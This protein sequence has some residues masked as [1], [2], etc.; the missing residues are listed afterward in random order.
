METSITLVCELHRS[1]QFGDGSVLAGIASLEKAENAECYISE[2]YDCTTEGV[3]AEA[4]LRE[5]REDV[6][7][8][9]IAGGPH[10]VAH[11]LP[12]ARRIVVLLRGD[13]P[14]TTGAVLDR[15][16]L[17]RAFVRASR[18]AAPTSSPAAHE[19]VVYER[20]VN[21]TPKFESERAYLDLLREL[22]VAPL[23][24]DRTGTGTHSV[25][26][27]QL[28]FDLSNG[29]LPLLT[30]RF[31]S[32]R[33]VVTELLWF[34][35]GS[36]DSKELEARGFG[37]WKGNSSREFLDARGLHHLREGDIGAAYGFQWRHFGAQ[38]KGCDASHGGEG[39]DQLQAALDLLRTDPFSRRICLTA[40][41]PAALRNMALP[42]CHSCFVQFYVDNDGRGLRCHMYQRSVDC[43]LGLAINIPSYALLTNILAAMSGLEARELIISTG[44]TH[45]YDDHMEQAATQLQRPPL[46]PPLLKLSDKISQKSFAE[47]T[48]DDFE[49]SGYL[50]H[51]ALRAPMSV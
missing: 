27:R 36:T 23:R 34:V 17:S 51:P 30:T 43:Y 31:V 9:I 49:I 6:S 12:R 22:L 24:V 41:N 3:V 46:P 50:H 21:E 48:E 13:S 29:A 39:V 44:D 4:A 14:T 5:R 33:L 1:C 20:V 26:G 25:F 19:R 15:A 32:F 18:P 10:L 45:L 47:L 38:Y 11:F 16:H 28:R 35:R 7:E 8:W 2:D 37:I 42:P 40:W